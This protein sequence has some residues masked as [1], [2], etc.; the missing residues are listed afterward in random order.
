MNLG[1]PN[2]SKIIFC[3]EKM[4]LRY[5]LYSQNEIFCGNFCLRIQK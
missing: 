3:V 5:P 2:N 4:N 1:D